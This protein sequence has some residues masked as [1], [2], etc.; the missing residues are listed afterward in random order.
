MRPVCR[1]NTPERKNNICEGGVGDLLQPMNRSRRC[2]V[3]KLHRKSG[4]AFT[5]CAPD[6]NRTCD[7]WY[8]K[9]MLYPL[10]YGGVPT[11]FQVMWKHSP[12]TAQRML[13]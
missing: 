5:Y 1:K 10:S 8:R 11:Q 2:L 7:L 3:K 12:V 6:T 4:G 13:V 9:P